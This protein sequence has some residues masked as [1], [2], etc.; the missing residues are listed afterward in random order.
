MPGKRGAGGRSQLHASWAEALPTAPDRG[1]AG[2]M[3]GPLDKNAACSGSCSSQVHLTQNQRQVGPVTS[4]EPQMVACRACGLPEHVSF[5]AF[6]ESHGSR[7]SLSFIPP[8][9]L[10]ECW[11]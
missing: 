9:P 3:A 11:E 5:W 8:P 4:Y 2:Y 6:P 1:S 7:R 10:P